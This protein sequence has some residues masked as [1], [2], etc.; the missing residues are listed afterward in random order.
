ME[1]DSRRSHFIQA[2]DLLAY[3]VYR[4]A[5]MKCGSGRP[6]GRTRCSADDSRVVERLESLKGILNLD[7]SRTDQYGVVFYPRE[8]KKS[9]TYGA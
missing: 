2:A 4:Y 7:A 8:G 9:T 6:H 3:V 1:K 5:L